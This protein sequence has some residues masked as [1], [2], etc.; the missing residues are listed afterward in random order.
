MS[1]CAD[2]I[3][4][5]DGGEQTSRTI[6]SEI[7][8]SLETAD[9]SDIA[10]LYSYSVE[11]AMDSR[12]PI[13]LASCLFQLSLLL[14]IQILYSFGY[15]DASS[16]SM[17]IKSLPLFMDSMHTSLFYST[18]VVSGTHLPLVNLLCSLCSL[19]LLALLMKNDNEGTLLTTPPLQAL[20]LGDGEQ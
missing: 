17:G 3:S 14:S 10:N 18:S 5:A 13:Q 4:S 20:L 16:L 2:P 15:Y 7:A 19:A 8:Q 9:A 1:R 11:V 12:S 6:A